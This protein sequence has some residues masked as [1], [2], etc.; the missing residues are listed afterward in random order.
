MPNWK[1]VIVSGSDAVLNDITSSGD[2]ISSTLTGSFYLGTHNVGVDLFSFFPITGSG[3]IVSQS[4]LPD[5]HYNMVKIGDI[6]LVDYSDGVVNPS[7]LI[8]T[9]DKTFII[10]ASNT[11]NAVVELKAGGHKFYDSN[12]NATVT[13]TTNDITIGDSNV[14]TTGITG[15]NTLSLFGNVEFRIKAG[16]SFHQGTYNDGNYLPIFTDNPI[17]ANGSL[18]QGHPISEAFTLLAGAVTASAVSSSGDLFA[19]L[20]ENST[21]GY[22]TVVYDTATGQFFYTGSYGGGGGGGVSTVN[23]LDGDITLVAGPGITINGDGQN[24]EIS[25]S[26]TGNAFTTMSVSGQDD[27]LADGTNDTLN[28]AAG[29]G[30]T[31]NTVASSDTIEISSSLDSDDDWHVT[32][33]GLWVTSSRDVAVTGSIHVKEPGTSNGFFLSSSNKAIKIYHENSTGHHI[34]MGYAA[35][36]SVNSILAQNNVAIGYFAGGF[37][38]A[39][40]NAV[41]I[42]PQA[43]YDSAGSNGAV[44]IGA[45]AGSNSDVSNTIAIGVQAGYNAT[46]DDSIFIGRYAG[47]NYTTGDSKLIIGFGSSPTYPLIEGNLKTNKKVEVSGSLYALV[48]QGNAS[49]GNQTHNPLS[50]FEIRNGDAYT[51]VT[52]QSVAQRY[53]LHGA[54]LE[55]GS[56]SN[57]KGYPNNHIVYSKI[58]GVIVSNTGGGGTTPSDDEPT[59][60]V[61]GTSFEIQP[62]GVTDGDPTQGLRITPRGTI[63]FFTDDAKTSTGGTLLSVSASAKIEFNPSSNAMEFFAGSTNEQLQKVMFVSKSGRNARIGIGTDNPQSTFDFKDVEDSTQGTQ[64]FLRSA[65]TDK[66]ADPNDNA[67]TVNFT[68]DSGSY[69]DLATSGSIAQISTEVKNVSAEGVIGDLILKAAVTEK[70]APIEIMRVSGN[71]ATLTGSFEATSYSKANKLA[72]GDIDPSTVANGSA[73]IENNL[74]VNDSTEFGLSLADSHSFNGDITASNHISA[75]GTIYAGGAVFTGDLIVTGSQLITD[76]ITSDGTIRARVKSFDIPHPTRQGKRLVYG[77]LEG[78]EHGIYCRGESRELQA[79]L[80]SEWR[81]LADKS[82]VT[83]QITPIGE[84]QPIYYKK[85]H[86]NWIYFGC[87]DD[88]E[89]Y[90]FFWE[91]KG[92]RTDVPKLQTVQ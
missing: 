39:T 46:S 44:L 58:G 57:L 15:N 9:I 76:D 21:T 60:K 85:L 75:S 56:N 92:E 34:F 45:D 6:E 54:L 61:L 83:V 91:I 30:I 8:D 29:P 22:N 67:G 10:S 40:S 25:G 43:G 84:W 17:G 41:M 24:I 68:I 86:N 80:P 88:R 38:G 55:N 5:N 11:N 4:N 2:F 53:K 77:A 28:F 18:L 16:N 62:D 32:A 82:G 72:I 52:P 20:T 73:F 3:I 14:S 64:L 69:N 13:F 36:S 1:K 90:H 49:Y 50:G 37:L 31:I 74:K 89:E 47:K 23:T 12:G 35:G 65:R 87:G 7:F 79:K 42:G 63:E 51:Y 26:S 27:I 71:G 70:D 78:P 19:G 66:G 59:V 48:G 81:S 33:D